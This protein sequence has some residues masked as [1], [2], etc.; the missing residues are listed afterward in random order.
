MLIMTLSPVAA[1]EVVAP[2]MVRAVALVVSA[3]AQG[4]PSSPALLT[5]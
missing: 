1:L 5:P 3:V 4:L 2:T